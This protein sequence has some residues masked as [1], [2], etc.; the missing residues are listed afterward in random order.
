LQAWWP[1]QLGSG[2]Q[3]DWHDIFS[4]P[5]DASS[6]RISYQINPNVAGKRI[7]DIPEGERAKTPLI[8]QK[9]GS[10]EHQIVYYLNGETHITTRDGIPLPVP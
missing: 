5:P 10:G 7:T 3:G 6:D 1:K 8:F 2:Q 4:L 9:L